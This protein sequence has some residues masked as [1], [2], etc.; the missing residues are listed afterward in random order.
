MT[1]QDLTAPKA[2]E[3][4]CRKIHD[5]ITRG[6]IKA[7]DGVK[8][9]DTLRAL[10]AALDSDRGK[11]VR[12]EFNLGVMASR[13][14][15]AEAKLAQ[16]D[17]ALKAADELARVSQTLLDEYGFTSDGNDKYREVR[18]CDIAG[19]DNARAAYRKTRG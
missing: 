19:L 6:E 18:V 3:Y 13:A 2:V 10:A 9:Q 17:A 14:Q 15:V 1:D 4:E 12:L 16:R 7:S 11:S 5:A 8:W